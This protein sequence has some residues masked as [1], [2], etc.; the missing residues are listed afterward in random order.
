M[1]A[2]GPTAWSARRP[3]FESWSV[4]AR[5]LPEHADNP[6]HTDSG[7]RAAG[8]PAALVA[9]VTTY[10]YLTHPVVVAWGR[11]WIERGGAEVRFRAPVFAER[12]ITCIPDPVDDC[13]VTVDAVDP[14]EERPARALVHATADAGR[15]PDPRSGE[16]L[17]PRRYELAGRY[18]IDYGARAGDDLPLYARERIVHPAV[19]PAIANNVFATELAHGAWIHVRSTIRHH[20]AAPAGAVVDVSTTVVD[21]FERGGTRAIADV[22]IELDGRP[23]ATIEHEAIVDL[24][25]R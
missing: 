6:I 17:R 14:T 15:P 24:R 25:S 12:T 23:V 1:D 16:M 11:D 4:T 18:G 3:I 22:R 8:F 13:S 5:N 9:G 21:R 19:W 2:G 7:A 10:A 20:T